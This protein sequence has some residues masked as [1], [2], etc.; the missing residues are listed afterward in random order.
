MNSASENWA[1]MKKDGRRKASKNLG[2]GYLA[3]SKERRV[4]S[5]SGFGCLVLLKE[6]RRYRA[7]VHKKEL[8]RE[9]LMA[10]LWG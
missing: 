7:K 3:K 1:A 6:H 5:N 10:W 2:F 8:K 4:H 9:Q